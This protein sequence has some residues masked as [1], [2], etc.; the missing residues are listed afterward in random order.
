MPRTSKVTAG[1]MGLILLA[2]GILVI[3]YPELIRYWVGGAFLLSGI[4][5]LIRTA[6]GD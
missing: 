1:A 5:Q 4:S 3:W 6:R 2:G